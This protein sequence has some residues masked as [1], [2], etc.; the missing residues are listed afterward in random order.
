MSRAM[1]KV[2]FRDLVVTTLL[3][4]G[5]V[6]FSYLVWGIFQ[7]EERA[8]HDVNDTKEEL[9]ALSEQKAKLESDLAE[10]DT[11]R[12]R[13]AIERE[14]LGVAKPGEEVIIVVPP[15]ATSSATST[16][17]WWERLFSWF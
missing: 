6:W 12:G 15:T 5:I 13:E 8:R 3:V 14:T 17:P 10:L 2:S 4:L 7:K 9:A 16:V 11:E 1:R